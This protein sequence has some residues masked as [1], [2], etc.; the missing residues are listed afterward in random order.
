MRT[1]NFYDF[2]KKEVK[3]PDDRK[4][5]LLI[6][7]LKVHHSKIIKE[8]LASKNIEPIFLVPYTPELNPVELCFS[9][10]KGQVEKQQPKTYEGLEKAISETIDELDKKDMI[11]YFRHCYHYSP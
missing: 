3:L 10:I 2:L 4:Y 8:L 9:F 11:E 1:Q 5:Y 7:N 6:D